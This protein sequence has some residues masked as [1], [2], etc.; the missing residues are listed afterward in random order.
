M[1]IFRVTDVNDN[2]PVFIDSPYSVSV[3]ELALVNTVVLEQVLAVDVDQPG[4]FSTVEYFLPEGPYE[5]YFSFINPL[6]GKLFLKRPL[7]YEIFQNFQVI[8]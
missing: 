6:D 2:A 7:D 8:Y 1:V 4:S 5:D 3:S